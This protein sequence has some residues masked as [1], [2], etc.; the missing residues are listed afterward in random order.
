MKTEQQEPKEIKFKTDFTTEFGERSD[1]I[2]GGIVS[3]DYRILTVWLVEE[4]SVR[5]S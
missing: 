5:L 4:N 2:K 1:L 3:N